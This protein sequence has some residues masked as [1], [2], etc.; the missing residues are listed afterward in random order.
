MIKNFILLKN[1]RICSDGSLIIATSYFNRLKKFDIVNIVEKDFK[2]L[3]I[4]DQKQSMFFTNKSES[5]ENTN[6][7]YRQKYFKA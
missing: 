7:I 5:I 1:L 4:V 6:T 2:C 3:Q